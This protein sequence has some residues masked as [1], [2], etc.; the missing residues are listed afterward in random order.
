MS[1]AVKESADHA[2]GEA[3][4]GAK[5]PSGA[6]APA[7]PAKAAKG[8]GFNLV[9]ILI[10]VALIAAAVLLFT[11]PPTHAMLANGPLKPLLARFDHGSSKG[12]KGKSKVESDPAADAKKLADQVAADRQAA[13]AK[14]A[15][16]AQLQAQVGQ[17][18]ASPAPT[19]TPAATPSATPV[20]VSEDVKR[21]ATYWAG[22]DADKA[23]E[24]VKQLPDGYVKSVFAQMPADAV[25]DI[26]S[27]L[28]AKRAA[29]LTAGGADT[30]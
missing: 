1:E 11:L 29:R 9:F 17:L 18:T 4:A 3:K 13:A 23:A 14:D 24:I 19:T 10:P 30:P 20:V 16:I 26:M 12:A 25:S 28:P 15:Q 8:K 27:E 21:A 7:A 22:M 5:P 6:K 2:A